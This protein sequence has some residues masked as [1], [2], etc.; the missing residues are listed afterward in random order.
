ME[1]RRMNPTSDSRNPLWCQDEQRWVERRSAVFATRY[2]LRETVAATLAWSEL[3][4]SANGIAKRAGTT[5]ATVREHFAVVE[6]IVGQGALLAKKPDQLGIDAPA[7]PGGV[8]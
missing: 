7:V 2:A 3:G 1:E 6:E 5:E 8:K 4:Y